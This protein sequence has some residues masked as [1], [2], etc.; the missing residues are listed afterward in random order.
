[1]DERETEKCDQCQTESE[2][3]DTKP[4]RDHRGEGLIAIIDCPK[5][6]VREQ[7]LVQPGDASSYNN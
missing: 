5:C 1:M 4:L 3:I 2:V 7:L 6:G